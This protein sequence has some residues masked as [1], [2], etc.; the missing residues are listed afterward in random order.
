[1]A[2]RRENSWFPHTLGSL[3]RNIEDQALTLNII[4]VPTIRTGYLLTIVIEV[5]LFFIPSNLPSPLV[6]TGTYPLIGPANL[7]IAKF[8]AGGAFL[9]FW[10]QKPDCWGKRLTIYEKYSRP[11]SH[12]KK[13]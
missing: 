2:E 6:R 9:N 5:P 11:L 8:H 10:T 13:A 12:P 1:M 7:Q 4:K 3:D